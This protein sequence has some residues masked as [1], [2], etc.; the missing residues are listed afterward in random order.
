MS[1]ARLS[2]LSAESTAAFNRVSDITK[3]IN[4]FRHQLVLSSLILKSNPQV[5]VLSWSQVTGLN[6]IGIT[7]QN[8]F[9]MGE[10]SSIILRVCVL[11]VTEVPEF[12]K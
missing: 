2:K 8:V 7:K 6:Q 3:F 10:R 5:Y 12:S 11:R 1:S 4:Y 9:K